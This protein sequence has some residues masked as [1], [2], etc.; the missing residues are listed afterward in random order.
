MDNGLKYTMLVLEGLEINHRIKQAD[1]EIAELIHGLIVE[2][3][4]I[5]EGIMDTSKTRL[6]HLQTK[7]KTV[8]KIF[9]LVLPKNLIMC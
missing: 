2:S 8:P 9:C 1:S 4:Q 7:C 6:L 5:D 3:S